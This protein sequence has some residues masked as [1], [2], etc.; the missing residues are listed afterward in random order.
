MET[1][2]KPVEKTT[3]LLDTVLGFN[4]L[5]FLYFI[6][7]GAAVVI[8]LAVALRRI[9]YARVKMKLKIHKDRTDIIKSVT[10]RMIRIRILKKLLNKIAVKV[11]M[12]TEYS[13]EKNL[14]ISAV[15]I[16]SFAFLSLF[17]MFVALRGIWTVW[18]MMLTYAGIS[19][20]F[21]VLVFY[22]F[23]MLA[24]SR[25]TGKLPETYK[26]LNSRYISKGNIMKAIEASMD[27]FDRSVRKEMRKVYDVLR[28]NDSKEI[29]E[30]FRMIE[31]SYKN[32]YLT[33]LLNLIKQAYYKGGKEV[34]K[35]QFEQA[36]EEVL[37]EIEN[38]K[39]LSSAGRPYIIMA[40]LMVLC[41]FGIELFNK[42]AIG[43]KAVEFYT[44]PVAIE[45]KL[46]YFAAVLVFV[47]Y[48]LVLQRTV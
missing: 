11:S 37:T 17:I 48:M 19:A 3:G 26:L 8:L 12:Y 38:H 40:I 15:V 34:V 35:Q 44:S 16:I 14:Q 46:V 2:D 1:L 29:D 41:P 45:I 22:S 21:A 13:Y 7:L 30:V 33:L 28:K 31:E 9:R 27:D 47:A 43:T 23:N 42:S 25:F 39:D 20:A 18:Y 24:K 4:Y 5:D 32:D 10:Q 6:P 36:T